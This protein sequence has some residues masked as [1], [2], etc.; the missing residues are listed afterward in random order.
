MKKT[1]GYQFYLTL[2]LLTSLS[3]FLLTGCNS[4]NGQ[5]DKLELEETTENRQNNPDDKVTLDWYVNYSWFTTQWGGNVVSDKITEET[6]IDINFITP[7]GNEEEKFNALIA[8]D[9]LPDI[10]TL[11][12][13]ENQ[14][15]VMILSDMVY[16][17]NE[18]ADKYDPYFWQVADPLITQWYTKEDGNIYSY[19]NSSYKPSDFEEY[20]TIGAN[21]TFLVRKDIY[22]A[23]GKPDMTTPEGFK[24]AIIAA[25]KEFKEVNG[26]PLIPIGSHVFNEVGCNSFDQHLQNF[27]AIPYEKN[28]VLHDRY[29]D[30]EYI[31]WLK[32]FRELASEGYLKED[33]FI[34]TRVQMEEKLAEGRYFCMIYQRT[35]ME[36]QQKILYAN[37]P[38]S[39]Y[40]AVD[41][42][43]NSKGDDHVLPGTGINGWTVTL[44]SKNCERP[45]KAIK[46]FSYLMSEHGQ[47]ITYLGVPGVT[48]EYI[49]GKPVLLEDVANLLK[50]DRKKYDQI[51]GADNAYWMFQ[52]LVMQMQWK[53]ELE[54]PTRQLEEWTFPYNHYLGQYEINLDIKSE[55]S[56]AEYNIKRLWGKTL[57]KL[58]LAKSEEEFDLILSDYIIQRDNLGFDI[59]IEEATKYVQEAKEKVG[60][61]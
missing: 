17:L 48:Y 23:I 28:G 37:D 53:Q 33:V 54:E 16:P 7:T 2:L 19:P 38:D 49:D 45:D 41:G 29:T 14:V 35:D 26:K 10:I 60:I 4:N 30:P 13:W 39:I 52:D 9:T 43:K 24:N 50:T 8:S 34:D 6:G 51:Y 57:P 21:Q 56:N 61:D 46:L 47:K 18:L 32:L 44:I 42:P 5:E 59:Y 15:D 20:D 22:E 25:T 36:D 1:Q 40:I 55:A 31:R 27:L 12:W 58:L 3:L 11:G